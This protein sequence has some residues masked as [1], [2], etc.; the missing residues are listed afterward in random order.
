M[1]TRSIRFRLTVWYAVAL[2][3]A[4]ALFGIMVWFSLKS[5]LTE[6]IN[7]D[8][9]GRASRFERYFRAE[10]AENLGPMLR[11]E[12]E[13]FA[14]ALPPSSFVDL[15][16]DSP[17]GFAF[18]YPTGIEPAGYRVKYTQFPLAGQKFNL[19]VGA[20]MEAVDHTLD[21]LRFLLLSLLPVVIAVACFGGAWLSGRALQP[22]K[23]L[24]AA[25]HNISIE[26]LS[27]RLPIPET[28]DEL[29]QLTNVLNSMLARLE[30][31]VKT[32]SQFAAD[33]AHEL[34]TP[35]AVIR[36]TAELALRRD[37]AVESYRHSLAVVQSETERMTQLIE[38]LL[39][40][41][42]SDAK[43][44]E[45]P[46]TPLDLR[47]VLGKVLDEVKGLAEQY[48]VSVQSDLPKNAAM[49]SANQAALHRL[50]LI[51]VDNA[52]KF[53]HSGGK[54]IVRIDGAADLSVEIQ[55]FGI[56]I[57]PSD[58]PHIFKRFYRA[59]RA[60]SGGGHGLGL[61]LAQT[62]AQMHG[63]EITAE[64]V[65]GVGSTFTVVFSG[66]LSAINVTGAVAGNQALTHSSARCADR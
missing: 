32:L 54:V 3:A 33:A 8:L 12:L 65:E 55:D 20:S 59:D 25:A 34:R 18:R 40:L 43:V 22:V 1:T 7:R 66:R 52:L 13:E 50:F 36:T 53:S 17:Q 23:A 14:Q 60:R 5:S 2:G 9:D 15:R 62:I 61:P 57:S 35:L 39:S 46:R 4:L 44:A 41:A 28:G 11:D 63:A 24:T 37:R 42:R 45:M 49:I 31:A 56:G 48:Q 27:E 38:D 47:D 30:A 58:V 64:S 29:A 19:E 26:N 16:G 6:E 10:S 51:L 21:L